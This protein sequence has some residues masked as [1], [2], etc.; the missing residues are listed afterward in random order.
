MASMV[1]RSNFWSF[2]LA[3]AIT[4]PSGPPSPSTSTLCFV[5]F[6]PRSVGF[7]P[8]FFPPEAGLAHSGVGALPLPLYPAQFV[9]LLGEFRPDAFHD[10]AFAPALEPVVAGALGA[11]L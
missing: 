4:T 5:P 7:F 8:T 10:A 3:A 11:V 1:S 9:A 2:T 6:F